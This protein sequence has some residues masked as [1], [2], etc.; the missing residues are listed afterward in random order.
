[1]K[2]PLMAETYQGEYLAA[3]K[4]FDRAHAA[5]ATMCSEVQKCAKSLESRRKYAV[6]TNSQFQRSLQAGGTSSDWIQ[7]P[8]ADEIAAAL[9]QWQEA[10]QACE[11]FWRLM[12][13]E[14][15]EGLDPP[16][17]FET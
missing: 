3:M 7:W 12:D 1:M 14:Q 16:P 9:I 17:E 8:S 13:K 4:K 11:N 5:L 2:D 10:R 6:I 15:Q